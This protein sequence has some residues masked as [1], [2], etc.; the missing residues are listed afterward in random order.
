MIPEVR[1]P[2]DGLFFF[3]E[4]LLLIYVKDIPSARGSAFEGLVFDPVSYYRVDGWNVW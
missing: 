3:D 1:L 2:G 4:G